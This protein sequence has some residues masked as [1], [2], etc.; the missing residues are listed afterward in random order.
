MEQE[1]LNNRIGGLLQENDGL[2]DMARYGREQVERGEE[3]MKR[4]RADRDRREAEYKE[5]IGRLKKEMILMEK[6]QIDEVLE[7]MDNKYLSYNSNPKEQEIMNKLNDLLDDTKTKSKNI[8][9]DIKQLD[10]KYTLGNLASPQAPPARTSLPATQ[11]PASVK[12]TPVQPTPATKSSGLT[13]PSTS[14]KLP[15]A[16]GNNK[17]S[18]VPQKPAP[19]TIA[20]KVDEFDE[21][22]EDL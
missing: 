9:S 14:S 12:P 6:K 11:P 13:L 21:D 22:F 15:S 5:E 8:N 19:Q 20:A 18:S 4:M 17:P 10:D 1:K 7:H 16:T 2:R 3:E